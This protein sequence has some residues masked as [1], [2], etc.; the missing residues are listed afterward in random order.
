MLSLGK[1][2]GPELAQA[3]L[4]AAGCG[5]SGS[6]PVICLTARSMGQPRYALNHCLSCSPVGRLG[7]LT[8]SVSSLSEEEQEGSDIADAR[9]Q[10]RFLR[11]MGSGSSL[12]SGT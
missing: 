1:A 11:V 6:S 2:Q 3:A 12:W 8:A 4:S 7:G 9:P 10:E 5:V